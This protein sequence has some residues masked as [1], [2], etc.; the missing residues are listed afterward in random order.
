MKPTEDP[1]QLISVAIE[2]LKYHLTKNSSIQSAK[3][4]LEANGDSP[5]YSFVLSVPDRDEAKKIAEFDK[6]FVYQIKTSSFNASRDSA[7]Q[8]ISQKRL[9]T[10][11]DPATLE[12]TFRTVFERDLSTENLTLIHEWTEFDQ[13]LRQQLK[14]WGWLNTPMGYLW[15]AGLLVFPALLIFFILKMAGCN[16]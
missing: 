11:F 5:E 4:Y 13:D 16:F 10:F 14:R 9:G 12:I 3:L 7:Y 15:G 1:E 8:T 6:F 2:V